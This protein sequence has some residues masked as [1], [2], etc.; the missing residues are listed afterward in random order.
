MD[1]MAS[2][3]CLLMEDKPDWRDLFEKY[4]SKET[5]EA[6]IYK[7]RFDMREKAIITKQIGDIKLALSNSKKVSKEDN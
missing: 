5:L 3:S 1:I 4:L 2:N 6:V 7:D